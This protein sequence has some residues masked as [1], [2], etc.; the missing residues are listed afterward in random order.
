MDA[1][2]RARELAAAYL[3]KGD[4]TG[5]FEQL[6]RESEDGTSSIPWADCRPNPHLIEFWKQ[7]CISSSGKTALTIGCGLGDDAEQLAAWG[8]DTTAFDISESA[9]LACKARFPGSAIRYQ[10]ADLLNP[11]SEWMRRFDFVFEAYT[12]QAL[13]RHLRQRAMENMA[14]FVGAEG[15]LLMVSRG[16]NENDAEGQMPWPLTRCEMDQVASF[17]LREESFED[18][19]D[20][21]SLPVRRFRGLYR[22][23]V[24]VTPGSD[25]R[26]F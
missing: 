16:R 13:P 19:P 7:H 5:W 3:A 6:Y 15:Y 1:R 26:Y 21:E 2:A 17:G 10:V 22:R 8:F 11:P 23:S 18:F 9:I 20:S 25:P 4:A 24:R 12:L 14:D